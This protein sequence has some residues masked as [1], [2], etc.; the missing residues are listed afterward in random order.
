M[1]YSYI[2]PSIISLKCSSC[3]PV[4]SVA[5]LSFVIY[6]YV[7]EVDENVCFSGISG[8]LTLQMLKAFVSS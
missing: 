2:V 3:R 4:L 1:R 8:V 5:S 6:L 7:E